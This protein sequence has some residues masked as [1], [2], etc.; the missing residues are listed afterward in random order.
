M[1]HEE[2]LM[3]D[4]DG[5]TRIDYTYDYDISRSPLLL[6]RLLARP[7][8]SWFSMWYYKRAFI[9]RLEVIVAENGAGDQ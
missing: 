3:E 5:G 6:L 8:F 2:L 9:D 4:V 7:L 1:G